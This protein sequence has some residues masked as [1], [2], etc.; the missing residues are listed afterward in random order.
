MTTQTRTVRCS[1]YAA[2][3]DAGASFAYRGATVEITFAG[4][5]LRADDDGEIIGVY[6]VN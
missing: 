1:A 3:N 6:V 4:A 5:I 2:R